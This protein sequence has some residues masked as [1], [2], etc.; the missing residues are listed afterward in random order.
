M[1]ILLTAFG[2]TGDVYPIIAYG[3]A[4]VQ[5][6]HSVIFATPPLYR[7]E[8]EKAGLSYYEVPPRWSQQEFADFM[9]QQDKTPVPVLQL[10]NLY[11]AALG[12]IGELFDRLEEALKDCDALVT[13]YMFPYFGA[14]AKKLNKPFAVF[15]FCHNFIPT[16]K[17]PMEGFPKPVKGM[18]TRLREAY[19]RRT[20][21]LTNDLIDSMLN[22]ILDPFIR[23]RGLPPFEG[24]LTNP[25]PLGIVAVSRVLKDR[26]GIEDTRYQFTG[27]LRWQ[28]PESDAME[29]ELADFCAGQQVPVLTFGSVS[30]GKVEKIMKRFVRH[31]PKGKKFI[32][33]SGW[34]GLTLPEDR[35]EIKIVGKVSHDQLFKFAS[36]VVHHGGAGTTASVMFAGKPHIVVP[37]FADQPFFASEVKRLGV[38]VK[39]AKTRWPERLIG[40]VRKIEESPSY[41]LAAEGLMPKVRAEDGPR[42]SVE[43]LERFVRDWKGWP[44]MGGP[45]DKQHQE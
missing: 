8:V 17:F 43:L 36:M 1:R 35:P 42:E 39:I 4:L 25:G 28:A 23:E 14:V 44:S 5:R 37:H 21:L 38:G 40:A 15:Y 33:Q 45:F 26:R 20:W 6:G 19:N 13:S 29:K 16:S 30:F 10:R 31:W 18:P 22:H 32:L 41:K 11:T 7:A 3:R 2:S 12:F 34:A 24:W 9:A 27:Y